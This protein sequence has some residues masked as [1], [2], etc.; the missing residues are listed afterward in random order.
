MP[1]TSSAGEPNIQRGRGR[2]RIPHRIKVVLVRR[3]HPDIRRLAKVLRGLVARD[4]ERVGSEPLAWRENDAP[5]NSES[6]ARKESH[7]AEP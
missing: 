7:G 1:S 4:E 2:P 3:E 5:A 6:D